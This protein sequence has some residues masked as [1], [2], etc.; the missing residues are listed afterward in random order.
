MAQER[1][2]KRKRK[3]KKSVKVS[4]EE[5]LLAWKR[6]GKSWGGELALI[7][8]EWR[9]SRAPTQNNSKQKMPTVGKDPKKCL[10]SRH[11]EESSEVP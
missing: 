1:K 8:V 11:V 6:K 2:R 4:P 3:R 9:A 7:K 10:W 5:Q